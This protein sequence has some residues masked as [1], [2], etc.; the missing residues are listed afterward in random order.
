MRG[1]E[2]EEQRAPASCCS[3]A[4]NAVPVALHPPLRRLQHGNVPHPCE[5]KNATMLATPGIGQLT[6]QVDE[7]FWTQTTQSN[8]W[9]TVAV[10]WAAGV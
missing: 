3:T 7:C 2:E 5:L 1:A 9:L 6:Q 4:T 10:A 8:A